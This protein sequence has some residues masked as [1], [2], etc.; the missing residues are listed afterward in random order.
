MISEAP[1]SQ[2]QLRN[3]RIEADL[4]IVGAGMAGTCAAITAARSGLRVA[5]VHDRPVLGGNASSEFR[6]WILGATS[7][8]GNNNRW[9]REGGVI[10]ELMV[11]NIYRNPEGNPLIFDTIL[12]EKVVEEPKIRLLLNTAAFEVEKSDSEQISLVRAF[13]SQNSTMYELHAPLFCDASGDGIVGFLAGA[14]FRMGAE[15]REEFGEALAPSPEYGGLLGHSLYFYS[16]DLGKPVKFVPPSFALKDI[17]AI[18]RYRSFNAQE[19]G[20]RL[21]WVE[22]GG[23]MDT[24]HQTE[25]IKWELW[26]IIYGVW[27]YIKNSGNFPEAAN[28]TL[29]WVGHIPGKRESRRFEGDYILTQRDLVERRSFPDAV[30]FGGWAL[31]LHPADGVYSPL[32]GCNQWHTRGVYQIPY[33]SL[34]SRNIRNLFLAGRI[35]SASHVAFSST[36][37][38]ATLAE[39][40]QAVAVAAAHCIADGLCPADLLEPERMR[41]LQRDLIRTGQYIPG[42]A[43]PDPNDLVQQASLSASSC[44]RFAGLPADAEPCRLDLSW[45]QLLPLQAGEI[46]SISFWVDAVEAT[47]LEVELWR[48]RQPDDYT[49]DILIERFSFALEAGNKQVITLRPSARLEQQGY[50]L[51]AIL[52]N[53]A[54]SIHKSSKLLTGTM[55][56]INGINKAVSNYG[57][58]EAPPEIG[59]ESFPFWIP[60]RRPGGQNIALRIEPAIELFGPE[61]LRN[62]VARPTS[63]PNAWVADW[64]DP[65]ASITLEWARPVQIKRIELSFDSDFDH[66]MEHVLR[67]HPETEMPFCVKH[68][69]IW[70]DQEPLIEVSDNHQTRNLIELSAQIELQRLSVKLLAVHGPAP[71]GLFEVRC[72]PN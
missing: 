66:A 26:R 58:Q 33:R 10:D 69:Q 61:N 50:V 68:Y 16:K 48:G 43:L 32:P 67:G 51:L 5:L 2:R 72:Y 20:C 15:S 21:W 6:L 29:E 3:E 56:L 11:E 7:H 60:E 46:P 13:C 35:I 40:A 23:R 9:A 62:G 54:I 45:G 12:L 22:Y 24:V 49:P 25:E 27:D 52:R 65:E 59:I 44:L 47:T 1:V 41:K 30:S 63:Q 31:D 71:A 39:A 19:Y 57:A 64:E 70:A 36:R 8:Q 55:A 4:V 38:Q 42:L 53:P 34:Y 17:T 28:L 14:A 37:V 18:P